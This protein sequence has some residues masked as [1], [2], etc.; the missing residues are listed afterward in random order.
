MASDK[1]TDEAPKVS[2]NQKVADAL[3]HLSP[4]IEDRVVDVLAT[5]EA[6]RRVELVCSG[7]AKL[8]ELDKENRK[9]SKPDVIT[10]GGDGET[11]A[12]FSKDRHEARGKL[13]E[14]M[15]KMEKAIDKALGGD[16]GDLANLVQNKGE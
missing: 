1:T 2:I 9:L 3:T 10:Y 4:T 6:N 11:S 8:D 14:K 15:V 16:L 12:V 13:V 5:K 7:L